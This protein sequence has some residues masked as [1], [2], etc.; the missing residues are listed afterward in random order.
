MG[1]NAFASGD[2]NAGSMTFLCRLCVSP[3]EIV[4]VHLTDVSL[5]CTFR[6]CQ[7]VVANKTR[8]H[9]AL[10]LLRKVITRSLIDVLQC[11]RV[12]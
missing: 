10:R 7:S 6:P 3:D 2:P 12:T 11:L 4:S 9:A 5:G 8:K 1:S